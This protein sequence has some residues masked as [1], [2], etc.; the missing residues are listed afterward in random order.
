MTSVFVY[1]KTV[2]TAA[3]FSF[4]LYHPGHRSG[5]PFF[6]LLHHFH[7][8]SFRQIRQSAVRV[9][10][11][12]GLSERVENHVPGLAA[13]RF[14]DIADDGRAAF[15]CHLDFEGDLLAPINER[16]PYDKGI[17]GFDFVRHVAYFCGHGRK[18]HVGEYVAAA[19]RV[20]GDDL[21]VLV[22]PVSGA[23]AGGAA[24]ECSV[25]FHSVEFYFVF[26]FSPLDA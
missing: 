8:N 2:A 20:P 24:V 11:S 13:A 25:G 16:L 17:S 15:D 7:V 26:D 4:L 5:I 22:K 14:L 18:V 1:A 21:A 19:D 3:Y 12:D 10:L 9:A 23:F 6:D